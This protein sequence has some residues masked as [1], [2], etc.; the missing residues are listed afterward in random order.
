MGS[1][2]SVEL[3]GSS[4]YESANEIRGMLVAAYS[5]SPRNTKKVRAKPAATA[6]NP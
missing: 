6:A 2:Q 1:P 3:S 4:P 5:V